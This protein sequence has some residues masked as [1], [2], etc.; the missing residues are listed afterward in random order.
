MF[1]RS[2]FPLFLMVALGW[3]TGAADASD[4]AGAKVDFNYDIRPIISTKCFHCHGPDEKSRKAKLRLDLRGEALKEHED[5]PTIV[6]GSASDSALIAR[7]TSKDAD[8]VMPPPKED[9]A[10]TAQEVQL[11]KRW[12]DQGA[13]YKAH[14]SFVKPERGAIPGDADYD[15]KLADLAKTDP[16]RAQE[17]TGKQAEW[18]QWPRNPID[19]FVLARML[20]Q[21][22][23][24]SPEADSS[25]L[26]RRLY[27]DLTGLPPSLDE[28]DTF[29]EAASRD[30]QTAIETLV[31]QLLAS[32]AYGERWAKMWLDLARYAD[33]TGYGSDRFRLNI[34]PYRDSVINAFNHNLPYD[35]FTIE[36]IA[37]DLLPNPTPEQITAT[38]FHRNTMTNTEGG[39]QPEEYRVAAVK[40]RIATTGQVWMGLTVGCAQCH[41][42]KF[43]PIPQTDYYRLFAVFNETED[44]NRGDE[45]PTLPLPTPEETAKMDAVKKE[46]AE[47]QA[48]MKGSTP[49]MEVEEQKW[50]AQMAQPGQWR[51]LT[52]FEVSAASGTTLAAQPD[53][54][55]LAVGSDHPETD[56]YKVKVRPD[57]HGITAFRVE[58]L[59]DDSLPA[60]G[61][62][63]AENGNAVLSE[64]RVAVEP[65]D[66][67]PVHGRYLRV[68]LPN[69][70]EGL[71]LAEVQVFS[72]GENI[73]VRGKASQSSTD[74]GGAPERAIDGNTNGNFTKG[75]SVSHTGRDKDPWW[76]VDLGKEA[77]IENIMIWNRTDGVGGRL[78]NFRVELLDGDRKQAWQQTVAA[79]PNP[80]VALSPDGNRVVA[81]RNA[82]AD[83]SQDGWLAENAIDGDLKTGWAFSPEIGKA[84]AAVFDTVA[85]LDAGDQVLALT[86]RQVY[87]WQH[88]IGRFRI[89]ATTQAPAPRELPPGIRAVLA[90][91]PGA[92]DAKQREELASYYRPL[93]RAYADLGKQLD[94]KRAALAAI[95][96]VMLP[97]MRELPVAR[98]RETHLLNKGNYLTP[99]DKVE[100][101]LLSAFSAFVPADE[102]IDRLTVARWL[103]SQ[104]NPLTARVAVNRFWA[105]LF[106]TGIVESEEDFGTQGS[107]PSHPQLLD[108]M[109]VTFQSRNTP[110]T[111]E[112]GGAG[113]NRDWNA[114]GM[115]W[116]MKA[117][118]K[119]IVTSATYRQSSKVT[120]EMLE[121]DGR[122]RFLSHAQRRR[123]DAEAVRDQ[124]LMLSGLL[125]HKLGGPSVYPPQPDGLWKVAFNGGQNAYPTSKGEDRYRRGIYTFWRRT[126]PY[127]SMATFDAP[128]RESCT[129]R[130]LPTNT[131]LQA[132]VTM[133]DPVFVECAQAL[134]RR[135]VREGG[136]DTASRMRYALQLCL[137]RPPADAQVKALTALY[138]DELAG[139][140]GDPAGALKL[141]TEPLGP[142]PAGADAA[143]MAAWMVV[144]NVLLN[145]DAVLTKS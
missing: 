14:W 52:P 61:P 100:P 78:A 25:A 48:K 118:L 132:F 15:A 117:M 45:E 110:G 93:S 127:P 28:M 142:L 30:P 129:L 114:I 41:T 12:I 112:D 86:L 26:C 115:G 138:E 139:Y 98:R 71:A 122:N 123:L 73:A 3:S 72:K 34:W 103:V 13:E 60:H 134:G 23:T 80:N 57:L 107:L 74:F 51:M 113:A 10:L 124:A 35:Q 77:E 46:I 97:V 136:N 38:A 64:L 17:V 75:K 144:A 92:R 68:T 32:P 96:P 4:P 16:K 88:T 145:L 2:L 39:V 94:A 56:T 8:E 43:D 99:G 42:H 79:P 47:I 1:H 18:R 55:F 5:G 109:A 40:D 69:A 141:S 58:V 22:L 137:S 101:G 29:R 120:P 49:E 91:D 37:G 125:S 130:R 50:E 95:K 126:M 44:A 21:G 111:N 84:H 19:H 128:S 131:P 59:P 116:D 140:R 105:Q 89:W 54:S 81:L 133:N 108:W 11:L 31:D 62:G 6:P 66:A 87:G 76:E 7:I 143:E 82:S 106:G 9:H 121:R 83:F 70:K 90:I 67:K 102:K 33:S 36:Q 20:G 119:L 135:I 27:F 65:R 104:E 63:R 85:P 53:G 24:P